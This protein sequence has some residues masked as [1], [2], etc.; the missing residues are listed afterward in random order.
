VDTV[1]RWLAEVN[2]GSRAPATAIQLTTAHRTAR[3]RF[4]REHA[5][6]SE[7]DWGK[8]MFSDESRFTVFSSD[9]RLRV[10]R[11]PGQ[12]FAQCNISERVPY[13]GGSVM[14]WGGI[15]SET[16]THLH[17]FP[18]GYLTAL[19]C[20]SDILEEYVVPFAPFISEYF[21]FM[22]DNA[23]PHVAHVVFD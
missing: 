1:R 2:L 9:R 16:K 4:A 19:R 5:T 8:V 17:A 3:L 12:R 22:Q 15:T 23:R 14:V 11:R 10:W 6:W 18:R 13:V 20:I 21:I 7:G